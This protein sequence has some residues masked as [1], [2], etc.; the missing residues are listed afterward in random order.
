MTTVPMEP[1]FHQVY[2]KAVKAKGKIA[3][4]VIWPHYP[5]LS[6]AGV[7]DNQ[8]DDVETVEYKLCTHVKKQGMAVSPDGLEVVCTYPS[9][10]V[11]LD[12]SYHITFCAHSPTNPT[13]M[14]VIS[15]ALS[16]VQS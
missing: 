12:N 4:A 6:Q 5:E 10:Y 16:Q 7:W 14:E 2:L 3:Y 1:S 11:C 13:S 15:Y 9:A 8:A